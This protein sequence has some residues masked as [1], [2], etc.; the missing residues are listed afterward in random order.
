MRIL[1][2]NYA[3]ARLFVDSENYSLYILLCNYTPALVICLVFLK[4][5]LR[6]FI[7]II[8]VYIKFIPFLLYGIL[9]F[10]AI[11]AIYGNTLAFLY[12]KNCDFLYKCFIF[13]RILP[14]NPLHLSVFLPH[15]ICG[16]FLQRYLQSYPVY[17]GDSFHQS[18]GA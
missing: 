1:I 16:G 5:N 2:Q 18:H 3:V 15:R 6:F 9:C 10:I 4:E 17:T 14:Q 7:Q 11:L 13:S 8:A 12:I